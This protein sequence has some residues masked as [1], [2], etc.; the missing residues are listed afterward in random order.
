M[1]CQA[2]AMTLY[3]LYIGVADVSIGVEVLVRDVLRLINS[4]DIKVFRVVELVGD[5]LA[6]RVWI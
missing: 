4:Y 5:C 2:V 3:L 6:A 1:D